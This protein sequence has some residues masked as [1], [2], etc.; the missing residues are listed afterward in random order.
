MNLSPLSG[1]SCRSSSA[2]GLALLCTFAPLPVRAIDL[3]QSY[4][5]ALEQ[6]ANYLASRAEAVASREALPQARAQLLPNVSSNLTR[7]KNYTDRESQGGNGQPVSD[8]YD[9][10][11]SNYVLS[12]R[13]PIYRKYNFAQYRQAQSQV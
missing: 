2:L 7:N 11:S 4:R 1:W 12:L 5:L 3:V 8:S 6:D 10:I 9:Y 13:Q